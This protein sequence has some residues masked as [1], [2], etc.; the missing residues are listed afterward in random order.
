MSIIFKP[1]GILDIA[2]DPSN[3]PDEGMKRCKNLR[4]DE[5][6]VLKIRDG[7]YKLNST[8]LVGTMDF[9]IEQGGNRYV[10]GEEY[11]YK[12]ESLISTAQCSAPE[13]SPEAGEYAGAQTVTITSD[14]VGT[15][16]FYTLDG[17]TPSRAS[18]LYEGTVTVALYKTLKAIAV[19]DG[20]LDSDVTVGYYS[21][22][23]PG[24]II[25]ET[26]GSSLITETDENQV[27]TEGAAS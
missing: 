27:T 21:S 24:S 19:R 7:S 22:T 17:S 13:Y 12:N 3:L 14:T 16:I 11:I 2:T 20:F 15:M 8:A 4:L 23:T 26:D 18:T 25:T 6:G 1:I 10:F 9:I 5:M